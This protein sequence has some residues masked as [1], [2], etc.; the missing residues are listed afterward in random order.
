ML[1]AVVSDSHDAIPNLSKAV[2]LANEKGAQILIHCGDLISPFMLLELGKFKGE[3][4]FILGNN[5]GDIWLLMNKLKE[6]PGIHCH[7]QQAF[8]SVAGL[9]IAVVHFPAVAE[10]LAATGKYDVVFYGHTHE[11]DEQKVNQTLLL[12]PGEILGKNGPPTMMFF[13]TETKTV[14]KVVLDESGR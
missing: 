13:D 12:N 11:Y 6:F 7:G 8:L 1:L 5:P 4:H 2:T 10:G 9:N 3:V 14:T